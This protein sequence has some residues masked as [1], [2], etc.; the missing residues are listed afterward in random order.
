[1]P[2]SKRDYYEVLGLSRSAGAEDIKKAYR[3]CAL[4][5]HPDRNPGN[6]KAEE[7]FK[8]ATEAYQVLADPQKRGLYDQY[9]HA[10]VDLNNGGMHGGFSGGGF[11]DIFEGIFED[12]FSAAG[13]T[14]RRDNRPRRGA[15]LRHEISISFEEA[16]FGVEKDLTIEREE[17][18]STCKGEGAKSGT[19]KS[20]C[21]V[22][23]GSGQVMASSGFF[24]ISRTCHKCHGVGSWI[25]HPCTVC[26]G[27]GRVP[28]ARKIHVKIPAGVDSGLRL[29]VSGEGEAGFA[30]GHRGDLYVDLEV[31]PHE[32]FKRQGHNVLCEVPISFVQAA[33]GAEIEVPT[34]TG[35]TAL[36]IPA[37]SQSGRVF[38]LKGKGIASLSGSG[39]GD[40]E[41]RILVET[42]AHLSEKQKDLLKQ[43]AELSGEKVNPLSSTFMER[44]K[45]LFS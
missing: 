16:A 3:K 40:E 30:G 15:D 5:H 7:K 32:L 6:V 24:S 29:R 22:C 38:R 35:S 42:P 1:M 44:M 41:V 27:A 11:A 14:S 19:S 26:K 34:L 45:K 25:D 23:K 37:G 9:G 4:A 28:V 21:S 36:K 31:R 12:F 33:L 39:I 13:G 17:A 8:E 20:V 10:G 18:C 43:F 2:P